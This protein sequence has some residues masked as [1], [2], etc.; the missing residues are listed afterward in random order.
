MRALR[1]TTFVRSR[2]FDAEWIGRMWNIRRM[3]L[4]NNWQ[5]KRLLVVFT[6]ELDGSLSNVHVVKGGAYS[7]NVEAV[8]LMK[9]APKF[10]PAWCPL[11]QKYVRKKHDRTHQFQ[12]AIEETGNDLTSPLI[13]S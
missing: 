11:H 8:R 5:G 12:I 10:I 7:L 4:Q 9:S 2:E 6:V 3:R 1:A 13:L